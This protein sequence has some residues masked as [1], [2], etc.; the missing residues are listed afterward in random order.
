M[1]ATFRRTPDSKGRKVRSQMAAN[2]WAQ[3]ERSTENHQKNRRD[4][5]AAKR[6]LRA[7]EWR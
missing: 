4:R 3:P 1:S 2:A 7:G 6:D 5:V